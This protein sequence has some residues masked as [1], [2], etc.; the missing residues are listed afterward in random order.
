MLRLILEADAVGLTANRPVASAVEAGYVYLNSDINVYNVSDTVNWLDPLQYNAAELLIR[1]GILSAGL[2]MGDVIAVGTLTANKVV[3]GNGATN[4]KVVSQLTVDATTGY[5]GVND[6]TPL[7]RIDIGGVDVIQNFNITH[8]IDDASAIT[9]GGTFRPFHMFVNHRVSDVGHVLTSFNGLASGFNF[10]QNNVAAVGKVGAG[11]FTG[12]ISTVGDALSEPFGL[13]IALRTDIG[14]GYT[15]ATGP[16][17]RLWGIDGGMHGPI[18]VQA[19]AFNGITWVHNNHY[20]GS[21]SVGAAGAMWLVTK[22]NSGPARDATHS[23][24]NTYPVDVALGIVGF[25]NAGADAIGWTTGIQIGGFGSMWMTSGTSKIGTGISIT[26]TETYGLR[27]TSTTSGPG[28]SVS[29]TGGSVV[30]GADAVTNSNKFEVVNTAQAV[31]RFAQTTS[32]TR[33]RTILET[34][35]AADVELHFLKAGVSDIVIGNDGTGTGNPFFA[36]SFADDAF[37][38]ATKLKMNNAGNMI[39]N[40]GTTAPSATAIL[41][42][43]STVA[44][45]LPPVMTTTERDAIT[46]PQS[47]LVVYNSTTGKLNVRGASAWEAVTSI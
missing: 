35:G 44:G 15:Q 20:N 41:E 4:V 21:P 19:E 30:I 36:L 45:F 5:L 29:S 23:S 6:T 28:I 1:S 10:G 42:L 40:G 31:A 25:S 8:F 7:S 39:I 2:G 9:P 3:V 32:G 24:A 47:G 46:S 12:S 22:K 16:T 43:V 14:T 38:A 18:A 27:I 13:I 17:G 11:S 34:T 26:Q 37:G 33:H